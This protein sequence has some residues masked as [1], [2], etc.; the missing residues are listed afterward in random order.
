MVLNSIL[1][2]IEPVKCHGVQGNHPMVIHA[3]I[4]EFRVEGKTCFIKAVLMDGR[5]LQ[6]FLSREPIGYNVSIST[7]NTTVIYSTYKI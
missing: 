2:E 4:E 3:D 6:G 1:Q 5:K 7:K